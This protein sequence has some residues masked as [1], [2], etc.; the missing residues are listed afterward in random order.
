MAMGTPMIIRKKKA[1]NM[2]AAIAC[3][4]SFAIARFRSARAAAQNYAPPGDFKE[5]LPWGN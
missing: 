2:V 3:S 4:C 5:K 1:M